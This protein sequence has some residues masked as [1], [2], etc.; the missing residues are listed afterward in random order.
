MNNYLNQQLIESG[1]TST[2]HTTAVQ[3]VDL[4]DNA[5]L[6]E[7]KNQV[8]LWIENDNMIKKL[9]AVLK[10]RN[11]VKKT[12]SEKIL[13]FMAKYNIED[14]NTKD[15]S[16]LRYKVKSTK[17]TP[18]KAEIRDRLKEYFGKVDN[19]DELTKLVFEACEKKE[20]PVLRRLKTQ[21]AMTL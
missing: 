10:E 2:Q 19:L 1:S 11:A 16:K 7:F 21:N 14:L 4:P 18:T 5:I 17:Q 20:T 8:R 15:G 12:L 3:A 6:D 13:R 9:Q